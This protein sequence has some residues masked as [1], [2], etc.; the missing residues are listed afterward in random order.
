MKYLIL[1]IAAIAFLLSS[2]EKMVDNVDLPDQD[3][4]LVVHCYISPDD[5]LLKA[6]VS[7]SAPIFSEQYV[8]NFNPVSN[9]TVKISDFSNE[10]QLVYDGQQLYKAST[11]A[12]PIIAGNTYKITV[13]APGYTS[14]EATTQVPLEQNQS[15]VLA[16]VDSLTQDEYSTEIKFKTEFT[17]LPGEGHYYRIAGLVKIAY[18]DGSNTY[19][20]TSYNH[21]DVRYGQE[22]F[23]DRNKD[24]QKILSELNYYKYNYEEMYGQEKML[25][26][27]L[28]LMTCDV[29]YY[30]MH[31]SLESYSGDDP[32]SE[33]AIIY[34]NI[35]NGLGVFGSYRKYSVVV[36]LED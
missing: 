17:D 14:V 21:L 1:Y 13:S 26:L 16:S 5:S 7:L 29:H 25:A 32:F 15:L 23:S 12:F 34:T 20:D 10:I 18:D 8:D 11:S 33:P 30:K 9:A 3:P 2:C 4:K 22:F 35:Q 24:G 31:K 19:L 28:H 36:D 6:Y 27:S